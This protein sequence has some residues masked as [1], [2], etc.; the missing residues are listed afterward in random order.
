MALLVTDLGGTVLRA[1]ATAVAI[2]QQDSRSLV[3][4]ALSDHI[5]PESQAPLAEH[6]RLLRTGT[7]LNYCEIELI[8]SAGDTRPI[9]LATLN[10]GETTDGPLRSAL[11]DISGLRAME[12]GLALAASVVEHTSDGVMV[13][14][15]DHRIIAV[16]PAFT[17]ITGYS[18]HE[19]LGQVP[20]VFQTGSNNSGLEQEVTSALHE[21]GYWRGEIRSRRK[22]GESYPEWVSVSEIRD[23]NGLPA[24]YVCIFSDMT[25]QEEAKAQLFRL[26]YFDTL[27]ALPNRI[28]LLE[29]L[30]LALTAARRNKH[31]LGVFYLDLDRFK[32][33]NDTLGHAVGDQLLRFIAQE[34]KQLVRQTDTVARL[35]GDEFTILAPDL[36]RDQAAAQIATKIVRHFEQTPF[37]VDGREIYIRVSIGISL[38]P[39]DAEDS[40]GLLECADAAMYAAKA[41][42]RSGFRFHSAAIGASYRKENALESE[43]H[44]ALSRNELSLLFQPQLCLRSFRI[45]G[46]EV[47]IGWDRTGNGIVE[48]DALLPLAR[49][50]ELFVPC[51]HWAMR[52]LTEQI[53]KWPSH[54][55]SD[56]RFSI[57][58]SPMQLHP[59]HMESLLHRLEALGGK[60]GH[61]LELEI[62]ESDLMDCPTQT[63]NMLTRIGDF[64][65]RL[66]LDHWGVGPTSLRQLKQLPLGRVKL[67]PSIVCDIETDRESAKLLAAIIA[68]AH[69]L[70]LV[71]LAEGVETAGQLKIL[72]DHGCDEAQGALFSPPLSA[73]MLLATLEQSS[74]KPLAGNG[75]PDIRAFPGQSNGFFAKLARAC[76]RRDAHR[77]LR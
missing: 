22:G 45:V 56:L 21:R 43:L 7:S 70:K 42:G 16:N 71:V 23:D 65:T 72:R 4:A 9:C 46:C 24:H 38:F 49:K 30:S 54:I 57:D 58:I 31:L 1:N 74:E 59:T 8:G 68:V 67:D 37:C 11:L 39:K 47:S 61:R 2:L 12:A 64:G 5:A 17:A 44:H 6:L 52:S 14:D 60:I 55:L 15:A 10:V 13:T 76:L 36:K 53:G 19:M 69:T 51:E 75:R 73:D 40:E 3:G 62:R 33:V 27:T 77:S 28:S 41:A 66:A 34:L 50:T 29:Q 32:E 48:S 18:A 63:L 26:A 35:G 20:T 25:S